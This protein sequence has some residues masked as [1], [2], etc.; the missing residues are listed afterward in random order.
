MSITRPTKSNTSDIGCSPT[1]SNC[2]TWQGPDLLCINLCTG[3]TVSDVV[4]KL[5]T[6]LC[7][8]KEALNLS[9]LDLSGLAA[10]C[11]TAQAP[12]AITLTT[13]LQYLTNKIVC[14]HGLIPDN[15]A[16]E[17]LLDIPNCIGGV[18]GTKYNYTDV[19][20]LITNKLVNILGTHC[21]TSNVI[22]AL[23]NLIT[24]PQ[25][26]LNTQ[27]AVINNRITSLQTQVSSVVNSQSIQA[28]SCSGGGVT[29]LN[30]LTKTIDDNVCTLMSIFDSTYSVAKSTTG[31]QKVTNAISQGQIDGDKSLIQTGT[32]ATVYNTEWKQTAS[33]IGDSLNNLW[34]AVKDVRAAV[35]LIQDNCCKVTCD[36][37]AVSFTQ[38][39]DLTAQTVT[40]DFATSSIPIGFSDKGTSISLTDVNGLA[41]NIV[42]DGSTYPYIVY[43]TGTAPNIIQHF[44][45]ITI[46]IGGLSTGKLLIS[47][48]SNFVSESSVCS[49]CF[50]K[51]INYV[52]DSC[53]A[54]TN[55]GSSAVTLTIKT[56]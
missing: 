20:N 11:T 32:L 35:Q 4:F 39:F 28:S 27:I 18:T 7:A 29:T 2:V 50:S 37:I 30:A 25:T 43:E 19:I 8:L 33:N 1:T 55:T 46:P 41:V 14:L 31:S 17:V 6:E 42:T 52:N 15:I 40:L 45:K 54:I 49:N 5:A 26:G 48:R 16:A 12:A 10:F 3:D 36:N 34:I 44:G 13:A 47:F 56:C 21:D 23:Y 51:E 9:D 38:T 53:C 22:D 24:D